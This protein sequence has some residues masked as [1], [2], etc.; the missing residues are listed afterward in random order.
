[1][2]ACPK[3]SVFLIDRC[4]N[5][6]EQIYPSS[7]SD[8]LSIEAP[9]HCSECK[10]DFR[11]VLPGHAPK[12]LPLSIADRLL[13]LQQLHIALLRLS[14]S[15]E[16]QNLQRYFSLFGS[17]LSLLIGDG[18]PNVQVSRVRR[19]LAERL[20]LAPAKNWHLDEP[21]E[22]Q[23]DFLSVHER[24][25]FVMMT[26]LLVDPWPDH[27]ASIN[28]YFSEFEN[29]LKSTPLEL[30]FWLLGPSN[31]LAEPREACLLGSS[32]AHRFLQYLLSLSVDA[33][34]ADYEHLRYIHKSEP[35][36]SSEYEGRHQ[37]FRQCLGPDEDYYLLPVFEFELERWVQALKKLDRDGD[38]QVLL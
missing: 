34:L 7:T 36:A 28:A 29:Q 25:R 2:T 9:F 21:Y 14:Q 33:D 30:P 3:H 37:K 19:F 22:G 1:V 32:L 24:A 10:Y 12:H 6:R 38:F 5:C 17:L 15:V 11:K 27:L 31:Y 16:N 23:F 8:S 26:S 35:L 13:K 4:P 18:F 20:D